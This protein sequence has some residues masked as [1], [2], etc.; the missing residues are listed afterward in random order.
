[1]QKAGDGTADW[2]HLSVRGFQ[3]LRFSGLLCLGQN[4]RCN[5][6]LEFTAFIEQRFRCLMQDVERASER[7]WESVGTL[8][9]HMYCSEVCVLAQ[10]GSQATDEQQ[11]SLLF[12]QQLKAEGNAL[13]L[14]GR[15]AEASAKY[16]FARF[17]ISGT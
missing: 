7:L 13:Y 8:N 12:A 2:A 17:N 15:Y 6:P 11:H 10:A 5:A 1:M 3:S 14:E 9:R 16:K 4:K